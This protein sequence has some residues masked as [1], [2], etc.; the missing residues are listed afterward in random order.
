M[1][2]LQ[3]HSGLANR[4][5]VIISGLHFSDI[6]QQ[7]LTVIWKKDH[8]L[9]SDFTDLFET[10]DKIILKK[11]N[12]KIR[13]LNNVRNTCFYKLLST[14]FSIDFFLFD[15]DIRELVWSTGTNNINLS[16]LPKDGT[17]FYFYTCHEFYFDRQYLK[18]LR[19]VK[20]IRENISLNVKSFTNKT[21]GIHIRRTDHYKAIEVSPLENFIEKIR[22]D[23]AK[24]MNIN[25]F[26]ATDDME[27]E[28]TLIGLFSNKIITYSKEYSRKNVKGMQ[29]AVV[30]LYTLSATSKIYGSFNSSFSDMAARIGN[31]P[32][33]IIVKK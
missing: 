6:V 30:D 28:K 17:N 31:I 10:D 22:D 9:F 26:L 33:I 12:Y 13:I 19:P 2:Y 1:I 15:M 5:R 20:A 24:D 7:K 16:K 32:L 3:P 21:I 25:Y 11:K 14:I 4:F 18:H 8:S 23:L 29:D 27:V